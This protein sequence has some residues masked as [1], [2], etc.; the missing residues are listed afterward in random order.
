MKIWIA[1]VSSYSSRSAVR[2]VRR[3]ASKNVVSKR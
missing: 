3:T 2:G 1:S